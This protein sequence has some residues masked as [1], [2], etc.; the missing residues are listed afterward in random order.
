VFIRSP[1]SH[2]GHSV[3]DYEIQRRV[4]IKRVRRSNLL[5]EELRANAGIPPDDLIAIEKAHEIFLLNV[6]N[7]PEIALQAYAYGL[8][9]GAYFAPQD[10]EVLAEA[11]RLLHRRRQSNSGIASGA[12]RRKGRWQKHAEY[13]A[14]KARQNK[15]TLSQDRVVEAIQDG[16]GSSPARYRCPSLPTLKKF[17]SGLEA[18]GKLPRRSTTRK[19]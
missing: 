15:P 13:L 10:Q 16:W 12:K 17:V 4:L 9:I 1:L 7:R 14:V 8:T 6:T 19:S 3:V 2:G 11:D 18:E 5:A